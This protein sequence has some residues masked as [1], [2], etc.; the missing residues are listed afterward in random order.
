M[1]EET[2][3][4]LESS[5]GSAK[6]GWLRHIPGNVI[7]LGVVSFLTD[8]AGD[9]VYPLL[10]V[11]LVQYLGAGQLFVGLVEGVAE[12]TAALF[13]LVSGIWADRVR[14][15]S[16][17][18]LFGYSLSSLSRP[19]LAM[20]WHPWVVLV[21]RFSDRVGKGIR[22]SPRDAIIADSVI[23]EQRGKAY[24]LHRAFD[25]AGAVTG[26]LLATFLLTYFIKDLRVLFWIAAIPG[27]LAVLIIV[28]KVREVASRPRPAALP[29]W[30]PT[31]PK[32]RLRVF[33]VILFVFVLSCS[34]DAFLLLRAKELGVPVALLPM[35]WILM[36]GVM[37]LTAVPFGALSDRLGRR[38]VIL[39]GWI[40]YTLVYAG[41][42]LASATWQAWALFACYGLFYSFTE[43]SELAILADYSTPQERGKAFGWY[44]FIVGA[45]ALPASLIFGAVWQAAGSRTAFLASAG[46]S[47]LACGAMMVFLVAAKPA[48]RTK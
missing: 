16:K 27:A 37:M 15:R 18:V 13:K 35:I 4:P 9:M 19:F 7:A 14:D 8:V 48:H 5:G 28:W 3:K 12:S 1:S 43:P 20:A 45:G 39:I 25:H 17:L 31:L 21:V 10:P 34:S 42:A 36:N 11:F 38:R 47:A 6:P 40:V 44:H 23:P 32:G 46:I 30:T 33:L 29:G 24:G 2:T 26:P 41:F 22:S